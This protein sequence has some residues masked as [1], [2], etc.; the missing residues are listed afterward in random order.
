MYELGILS[1]IEDPPKITLGILSLI[2]NYGRKCFD[3][4]IV[5]KY[6]CI[7]HRKLFFLFFLTAGW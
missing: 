3:V 4:K 6:V 7:E 1:L 2:G 5:S